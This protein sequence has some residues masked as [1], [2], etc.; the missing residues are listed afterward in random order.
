MPSPYTQTNQAKAKNTNIQV[1]IEIYRPIESYSLQ[2]L[3]NHSTDLE[4]SL[5][6]H[7]LEFQQCQR[8]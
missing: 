3:L 8:L 4:F 7:Q 6:L 5:I 1:S 2:P